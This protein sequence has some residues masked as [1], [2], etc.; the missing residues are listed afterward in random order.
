[1]RI[2]PCGQEDK[3]LACLWRGTNSRFRPF[4]K[5]LGSPALHKGGNCADGFDIP[6]KRVAQVRV[7]TGNE[8]LPGLVLCRRVTQGLASSILR[9]YQVRLRSLRTGSLPEQTKTSRN[10]AETAAAEPKDTVV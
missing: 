5:A 3:G 6:L 1:M 9:T 2:D 4:E 8:Y 7:G 10:H